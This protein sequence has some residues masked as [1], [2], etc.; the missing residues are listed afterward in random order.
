MDW[1]GGPGVAG[2][3]PVSPIRSPLQW[4]AAVSSRLQRIPTRRN[5]SAGTSTY[6]PIDPASTKPVCSRQPSADDSHRDRNWEQLELG[7]ASA[8]GRLIL[9]ASSVGLTGAAHGGESSMVADRSATAQSGRPAEVIPV[10]YRQRV[11][12]ALRALPAILAEPLRLVAIE[13]R[14]SAD[15]SARATQ[16]LGVV[17]ALQQLR[18]GTM[19]PRHDRSNRNAELGY[20]RLSHG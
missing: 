13:E 19:H 8:I 6:S 14:S 9:M 5:H 17:Q 1:S 4:R 16:V 20:Y 10:G 15:L 18:P 3:S 2:S 7:N 11:M 12:S